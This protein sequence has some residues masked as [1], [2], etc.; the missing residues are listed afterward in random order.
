VLAALAFAVSYSPFRDLV[1]VPEAQIMIIGDTY[2]M[3]FQ[4]LAVELGWPVGVECVAE[5]LITGAFAGAL[6]LSLL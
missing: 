2:L 1:L 3:P 5:L 6:F 4:S